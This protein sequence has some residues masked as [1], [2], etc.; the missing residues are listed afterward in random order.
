MSTL[1]MALLSIILAAAQN[2]VVHSVLDE[3][4]SQSE[5]Q[6]PG[7]EARRRQRGGVQLPDAEPRTA[8]SSEDPDPEIPVLAGTPVA[9]NSFFIMV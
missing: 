7:F 8:W 3:G 9:N 1:D 5:V 2:S 4:I 6:E